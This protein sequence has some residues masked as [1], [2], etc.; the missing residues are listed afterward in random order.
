MKDWILILT[1]KDDESVGSVVECFKN[2]KTRFY[3]FNTEIFPLG[4]AVNLQIE[5][6]ILVGYLSDRN[7]TVRVGLDEIRSVWYR[8]PVSFWTDDPKFSEG[9]AKFIKDEASAALWSLYTNL[10]VFWMNHP[11]V[12]QRLLEHNKLYQLKDAWVIGLKIPD[13]I[14]TNN[15]DELLR[16]CRK[17]GGVIAV[18]LLKGGWFVKEESN[19]PLFIFT[20][21][22]SEVEIVE[23]FNEIRLAPI[24]AQ[25]YIEKKLEL[26]VTVVGQK[27]FSCA[28]YSQNSEQTKVDW[29]HYDFENVKHAP[30]QLPREIELK[31]LELM[32]RWGLNYGAIDMILTPDDEYVFLEINPN[33]QWLWIEQ[34]TGMPISQAIAELLTN[35][36]SE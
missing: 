22:V 15:P 19:V 10:N 6:G 32:E 29:R 12:S 7:N 24:F 23:R 34:L 36:P 33:G 35:P 8:R 14:I 16:F 21:M 9:C 31:I 1:N 5:N 17:C 4:V 11:L 27:I 3:R 26:R 30:Y 28:I 20:Q 18:K 13:T 25:S 2:L